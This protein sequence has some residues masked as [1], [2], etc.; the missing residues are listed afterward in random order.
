MN[1]VLKATEVFVP[2]AFPTLTYV[3]RADEKHENAVRD[4][5]DTPNTVISVS[6]PSKT[7]K[8]VLIQ[9]TLGED[10]IIP[11]YGAQIAQADDVWSAI[12]NWIEAPSTIS[13]SDTSADSI[14]PEAGL[15]SEIGISG[16]AKVGGKVGVASTSTKSA[17]TG[18]VRQNNG[19]AAV[20]RE[21]AKSDFTVFLDDF[22]YIPRELQEDVGRQIKA[23]SEVGIRF[24][25]ASV[26]HRSDDVV[27]SNHE[28]RGRTMNID[29]DYWS[30]DDL[31]QIGAKG[32]RE[33]NVTVSEEIL[34]RLAEES[35]TS[36]QIMQALCLQLCFTLEVRRR[37]DQRIEAELNPAQLTDV[38]EQTSGRSDF[39][40]LVKQM[41]VGPRVRGTE[42]KTFNFKDGSEGDAYRAALLALT[43][44]PPLMELNYAEITK[45]IEE[46]CLNEKP[47]GSSITEAY[48]Q[49]EGF[50]SDMYPKQKIIEW[51]ADAASGTLSII[52]PYFLFFL[53]SSDKVAELGKSKKPP[54]MPLF[55]E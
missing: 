34:K 29:T 9:K 21:I 12:L 49:I 6:G 23:G 28:L 16:F 30:I 2:T 10:N 14:T 55:G 3:N 20:S 44:D 48:K 7:G 36:P 39:T 11:I 4:A 27:R 52:D 31:V 53:R 47:V 41:H 5:S 19:L 15:S 26:P 33:M 54:K 38:L 17:M 50:A 8:T 37:P 43:A 1:E 24:C 35:C 22:H 51:D 25:I 32:F 13:V 46:V 40:S 18:Q 42:R 45:R